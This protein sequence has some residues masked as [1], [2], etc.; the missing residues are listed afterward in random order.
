MERSRRGKNQRLVRQRERA[1]G[2]PFGYWYVRKNDLA[3]ASTRS[4]CT[5]SPSSART[6][7][8]RRGRGHRWAGP[9]AGHHRRAHLHRHGRR[10]RST[11]WGMLRNPAYASRACFGKTSRL[12]QPARSRVAGLAGRATGAAYTTADRPRSDWLEIGV[13]AVVD[14]ATFERVARRQQD[15]LP[16]QGLA[17]C[18][19][20][21]YACYRGHTTTSVGNKIFYY[22]C[23]GS[24]SCRFE[25][26][27]VC[28]SKPVRADY[29][30]QVVSGPFPVPAR[31]PRPDPRRDRQAPGPDPHRR[32]GHPQRM[33]PDRQADRQ[34]ENSRDR[35]PQ[36]TQP[37]SRRIQANYPLS[38]GPFGCAQGTSS[39]P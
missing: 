12:S 2:C 15:L 6:P 30:N 38:A 21:G 9:V 24:D 25:H 17:A 39:H 32:T 8:R 36:A 35:E 7:L 11:I 23:I 13:P 26:G 5:R 18:S 20:C 31:R 3:A 4:C 22:R 10:A 16:L 37:R 19:G 14:E 28:D 34:P 1:V 27:G 29:L 33:L